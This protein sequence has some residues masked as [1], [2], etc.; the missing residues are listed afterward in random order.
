MYEP[1][2]ARNPNYREVVQA[3]FDKAP[4]V[5]MLGIQMTD[6]GP[7]WCESAMVITPTQLQQNGFVHAGM[8]ATIADHTAG[9]AAGS[10]IEEGQMVLSVEYKI[11]LLRPA[12]GESLRARAEVIRGGRRIIVVDSNVF[13]R[14]DG[15]EKLVAK[16]T[17]TLAAIE[18]GGF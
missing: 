15:E 14:R 17:V 16:A 18:P 12:V 11:N 6:L 9:A 5:Q 2:H 10:L 4:F 1:V 8:L 13:A 7:G 3:I